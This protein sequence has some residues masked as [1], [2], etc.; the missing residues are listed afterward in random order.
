MVN[1][2]RHEV[3]VIQKSYVSSAT[4][5]TIYSIGTTSAEAN[6]TKRVYVS[7]LKMVNGSSASATFKI[8]ANNYEAAGEVVPLEFVIPGD[9]VVDFT[10]QLPYEMAVIGSTGENRSI[11]ASASN[12]QIRYAFAGYLEK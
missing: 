8:Y 3:S 1:I 11:V 10:W 5:V 2:G 9:G 6:I 12:D 7:D 4:A